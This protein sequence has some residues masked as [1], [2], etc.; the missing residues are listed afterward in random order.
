MH[1][2][3]LGDLCRHPPPSGGRRWHP[4]NPSLEDPELCAAIG[5]HGGPDQRVPSR[6]A[7]HPRSPGSRTNRANSS[8]TPVGSEAGSWSHAHRP[9]IDTLTPPQ[10]TRP[11]A[12]FG[13]VPCPRSTL[14]RRPPMDQLRDRVA[15]LEH[16]VHTLHQQAH[17]VD[18][19]LRWWRGLACGL[20]VQGCMGPVCCERPCACNWGTAARSIGWRFWVI[21]D[22]QCRR[23]YRCVVA[24]SACPTVRC[25]EALVMR[26]SRKIYRIRSQAAYCA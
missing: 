1:H 25:T 13:C 18:R 17:A 22:D 14:E 5:R 23:S 8:L 6:K 21:G 24:G 16:Q 20:G 9:A 4:L 10:Y 2:S 19:Q 26:E 11:T 7:T 3:S 12:C 15:A